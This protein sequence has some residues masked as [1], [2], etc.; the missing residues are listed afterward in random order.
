[1]LSK[2]IVEIFTLL[3]YWVVL[4]P[5]IVLY[6]SKLEWMKW[7]EKDVTGMIQKYCGLILCLAAGYLVV[8][9][10]VVLIYL[11]FKIYTMEV[12]YKNNPTI[13]ML[14]MERQFCE[15]NDPRLQTNSTQN[16]TSDTLEMEDE[17]EPDGVYPK[18]HV[19]K[20]PLPGERVHRKNQENNPIRQ[21]PPSYEECNRNQ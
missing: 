11:R 16:Q 21:I 10:I 14:E 13:R 12:W 9:F 6:C 20:A 2:R 15:N 3:L 17:E 8:Y 18:R 19:R 5:M 1:M 4:T 7:D